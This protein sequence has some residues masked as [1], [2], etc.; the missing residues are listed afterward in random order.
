MFLKKFISRLFMLTVICMGTNA[1]ASRSPLVL[2]PNIG[3]NSAAAGVTQPPKPPEAEDNSQ[4]PPCGSGW[5]I[6]GGAFP[7]SLSCRMTQ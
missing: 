1:C 3:F 6:T 7:F 2:N 5:A 4:L